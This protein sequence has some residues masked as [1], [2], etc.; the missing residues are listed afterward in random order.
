MFEDEDYDNDLDLDEQDS[1][2]DTLRALQF[3][4]EKIERHSHGIDESLPPSPEKMIEYLIDAAMAALE[5]M[6]QKRT[7]IKTEFYSQCIAAQ[8]GMDFLGANY[9][10]TSRP[11]LVAASKMN[12]FNYYAHERD[13][14]F[15]P[16][17]PKPRKP[18]R[19]KKARR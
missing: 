19:R 17:K 2:L 11:G 6:I 14:I 18:R 10:F 1:T 7:L 4:E 5:R 16:P 9:R 12:V 3:S 13:K 8:K 15:R